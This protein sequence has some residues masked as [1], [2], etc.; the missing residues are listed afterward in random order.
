[1]NY[2]GNRWTYMF[3]FG[4]VERYGSGMLALSY[5]VADKMIHVLDGIGVKN[6]VQLL[7]DGPHVNWTIF[8]ILQKE[9][10]GEVNKSL[11]NIRSC[12]LHFMHNAFWDW[13]K[14]H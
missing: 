2:K 1:M 12:G 8:D 9:V 10:L 7:M 4:M 13:C 3:A 11:H 14:E 5:D 6:L